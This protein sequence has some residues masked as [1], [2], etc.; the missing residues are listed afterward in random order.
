MRNDTDTYGREPSLPVHLLDE[1]E[2][3]WLSR[4]V[5]GIIGCLL[6]ELSSH[7]LRNSLKR[8]MPYYAS[9]RLFIPPSKVLMIKSDDMASPV[10]GTVSTISRTP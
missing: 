9:S 4:I 5:L 6:P 1:Q 3:K 7:E 8:I 2:L 10:K